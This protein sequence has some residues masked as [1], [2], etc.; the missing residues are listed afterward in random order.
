[1]YSDSLGH[2]VLRI[3]IDYSFPFVGNMR[4]LAAVVLAA[5]GYVQY[6]NAQDYQCDASDY[7]DF[8]HGSIPSGYA[9]L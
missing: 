8:F 5:C 9:K 3:A 4:I 1:M 7:V 2:L 6:E